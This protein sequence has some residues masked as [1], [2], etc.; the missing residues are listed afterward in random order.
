M[1]LTLHQLNG[2]YD[3]VRCYRVVAGPGLPGAVKSSNDGRL[4]SPMAFVRTRT[5]RAHSGSVAEAADSCRPGRFSDSLLI[6]KGC[7]RPDR[8]VSSDLV[9]LKNLV[10]FSIHTTKTGGNILASH[11]QAKAPRLWPQGPGPGQCS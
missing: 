8:Y 5:V 2:T 6:D 10:R 1:P 9:S 4:S 11:P 3:G 7:K